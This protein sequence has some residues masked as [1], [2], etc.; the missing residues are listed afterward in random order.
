M[1][2]PIKIVI[3]P[4]SIVEAPL[5]NSR[6]ADRIMPAIGIIGPVIFSVAV[7]STSGFRLA[8]NTKTTEDVTRYTKARLKTANPISWLNPLLMTQKGQLRLAL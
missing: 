6:Y 7:C 3:V 8:L 4:K 5:I 1:G 2:T